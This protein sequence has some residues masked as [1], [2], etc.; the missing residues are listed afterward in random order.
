MALGRLTSC[1]AGYR[2]PRI[3][4]S[5]KLILQLLPLAQAA[6]DYLKPQPFIYEKRE[7]GIRLIDCH[8]VKYQLQRGEETLTPSAWIMELF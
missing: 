1:P 6:C 2:A 4:H 5:Q 3:P 7:A 8:L